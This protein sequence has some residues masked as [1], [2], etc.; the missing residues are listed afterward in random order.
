MNNPKLLPYWLKDQAAAVAEPADAADAREQSRYADALYMLRQ[1]RPRYSAVEKLERL[2]GAVRWLVYTKPG[3][4]EE[5][6]ALAG[7]GHVM[8]HVVD[9]D[10][11]MAEA[12]ALL[13]RGDAVRPW[14]SLRERLALAWRVVRG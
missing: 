5:T 12:I 9:E 10:K 4:E 13:F 14:L 6:E 7:L 8:A 3:S 2:A 11:S 1:A